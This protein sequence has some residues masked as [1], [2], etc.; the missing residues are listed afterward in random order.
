VAIKRLVIG[1]PSIQTGSFA[2]NI[3]PS[4][5]TSNGDIG[6]ADYLTDPSVRAANFGNVISLTTGQFAYVSEMFVNPPLGGLWNLFSSNVVSARSV[7]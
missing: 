1:N 5:I 6:S 4:I 7:F 3:T 2:P